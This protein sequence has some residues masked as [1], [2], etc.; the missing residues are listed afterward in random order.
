MHIADSIRLAEALDSTESA[1]WEKVASFQAQVSNNMFLPAYFA[2]MHPRFA[3][4]PV[5]SLLARHSSLIHVVSD[6]LISSLFFSVTAFTHVTYYFWNRLPFLFQRAAATSETLQVGWI[7]GVSYEPLRIHKLE[8]TE[9]KSIIHGQGHE[10]LRFGE[11]EHILGVKSKAHS[12]G[13]LSS[14]NFKFRIC[15]SRC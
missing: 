9:R 2:F 11:V 15:A 10:Q 3:M 4:R 8:R 6:V 14:H 1:F 13:S 7:E 5:E 12:C